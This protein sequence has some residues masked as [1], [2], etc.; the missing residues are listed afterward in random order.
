MGKGSEC[1][2]VV[3]RC[4]PLS[5]RETQGGHFKIVEMYPEKDEIVVQRASANHPPKIFTFDGCFDEKVDQLG[6]FEETANPIID[7]VFEGYNG[8]IFA[9]GQTGTGKT[10][11][12]E[13]ER[14]PRE[15]RGIMARTFE[16]VFNRID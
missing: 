8:T 11:T 10:H 1:I 12:M 16:E 13:G 7:N 3:I 5:T 9:Y 6:L 15:M 14:K 4:R 2:K